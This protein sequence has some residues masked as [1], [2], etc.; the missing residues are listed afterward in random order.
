MGTVSMVLTTTRA[1][2]PE[3]GPRARLVRG[4]FYRE[5]NLL[6]VQ[7]EFQDAFCL[8]IVFMRYEMFFLVYLLSI[9]QRNTPNKLS[10]PFHPLPSKLVPCL[11]STNNE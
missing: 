1:N 6:N 11:T 2:I 3:S 7:I 4:C 5:T 9:N 10:L 8:D